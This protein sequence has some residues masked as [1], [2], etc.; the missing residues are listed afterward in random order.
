MLG[1]HKGA[2]PCCLKGRKGG[3]REKSDV[4]DSKRAS[5]VKPFLDERFRERNLEP[6]IRHDD[7]PDFK[8]DRE[9]PQD[10]VQSSPKTCGLGHVPNECGC[11]ECIFRM[12]LYHI[13]RSQD[14]RS[15]FD[16]EW[17]WSTSKW[18][19]IIYGYPMTIDLR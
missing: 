13:W 11:S 1:D 12:V 14:K 5:T 9:V 4:T 18:F 2:Q 8:R 7:T 3:L 6:F 16:I 17:S 10:G 19:S 15:W